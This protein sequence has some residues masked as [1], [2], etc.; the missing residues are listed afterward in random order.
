V[1]K[2]PRGITVMLVD[3]H[4]V[5]RSAL[6]EL[7][8]EKRLGTIVA[9]A[10]EGTEV[11]AIAEALRPDLVLMD[12]GLPDLDGAEATRQLVGALPET[13][14]LVISA[15]DREADVLAAIRAGAR[16][17]L[18]KTASDA[19]IVEAVRRVIVGESVLPIALT[20]VVLRGLRQDSRN[21]LDV[22]SPRER[23]VLALMAQGRSN[24]AIAESLSL[25]AKTVE[26]HVRSIFSKLGLEA[27]ADDHR[28][29]LAVLAY[30]ESEG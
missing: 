8:E 28:R 29:V 9:E 16:G 15:S 20:E 18:L 25:N 26:A 4:P 5:W 3:D 12:M 19:E 6:R 14:V 17:Y 24:Q 2:P 27:T 23:E 13:K 11:V 1:T 22:I 30:L 21:T 7:V 10:S